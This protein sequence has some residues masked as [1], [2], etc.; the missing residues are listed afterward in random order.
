MKTVLTD[1]PF[2]KSWQNAECNVWF[3]HLRLHVNPVNYFNLLSW[4]INLYR[5]GLFWAGNINGTN[6]P[7][8]D[9]LQPKLALDINGEKKTE[10]VADRTLWDQNENIYMILTEKK[11]ESCS[12]NN[13]EIKRKIEKVLDKTTENGNEP[14]TEKD[15]TRVSNKA[16]VK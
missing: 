11:M 4:I 7:D 12:Q 14:Q 5:V 6:F 13:F 10:K 15:C 9:W 2:W 3:K 1:F 8:T 16:P